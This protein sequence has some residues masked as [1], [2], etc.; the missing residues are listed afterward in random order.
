M[1]SNCDEGFHY[2]QWPI[3]PII[4]GISSLLGIFR[5]K[6]KQRSPPL[7]FRVPIHFQSCNYYGFHFS[8]VLDARLAI[9]SNHIVLSSMII[10]FLAELI[11]AYF[12][13]DFIEE[14]RKYLFS[15]LYVL[16]R[17]IDQ[18][19]DLIPFFSSNFSDSSNIIIVVD[20]IAPFRITMQVTSGLMCTLASVVPEICSLVIELSSEMR[21][22]IYNERI[23]R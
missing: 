11:I 1:N 18:T 16:L 21:S 2:F 15:F 7:I 4:L 3:L 12:A 23:S 10:K 22:S 9:S 8:V 6:C 17:M 13:D 20:S 19:R 14:L 5:N